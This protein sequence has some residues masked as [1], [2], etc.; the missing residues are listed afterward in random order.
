[1]IDGELI[2]D[3]ADH[4]LRFER[5]LPHP[6]DRVWRA[7]TEPAGLAAW[8]PHTV[9]LELRVGGKAVFINDPS[10]DID[11]ELLASSGEVV[12]L[13]PK[14][15]FAFTWGNDLLRFELSPTAEGCRLVFTHRLPHRAAANRT[16]S[17]WSVCLDGLAAS[18]SGVPNPSPGWRHY[19][20]HYVGRFGDEGVVSHEDGHTVLRFERL[21]PASRERVRS[22][23]GDE[24]PPSLPGDVKWQFIPMGDT[25]LALLTHT[26]AGEWDATAASAEWDHLLRRLADRLA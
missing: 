8:F 25:A 10:F 3:G 7:I 23:L 13:D 21:M 19:Y 26:V 18:L 14:R 24:Q 11:P 9:E 5:V 12:E 17:G 15:R 22:A 16:V 6:V 1:V 4:V 2:R 20:D